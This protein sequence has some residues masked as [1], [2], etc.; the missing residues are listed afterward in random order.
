MSVNKF[1]NSND[2]LIAFLA[3]LCL[4]LSAVEFVIPKPL[5]FMRLGLANV[6]ILLSLYLLKPKQILFL[7]LLKVIGQGL[8]TGT[9]FSY[10]F[11]FSLLGSFASGCSMLVV[12]RVGKQHIGPI[13]IGLFGSLANAAS[14][15]LLSNWI[16]FG[17]SAQYIA[18]ILIINASITGLALG[19]VT[20]KFI[21]TS[22]WFSM[23][24]AN[25]LSGS[26]DYE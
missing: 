9:I 25:T 17:E 24:S 6:P 12:H 8:I 7:I 26:I 10:I 2:K 5:P 15:I 22:K 1:N 13:G 16:L 14:Q 20:A 3:S 4:F 18:P 21:D 19:V 23:I 11:L